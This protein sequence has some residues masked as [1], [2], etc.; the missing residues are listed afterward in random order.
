MHK[1]NYSMAE[2]LGLKLSVY[3]LCTSLSATEL[4]APLKVMVFQCQQDSHIRKYHV[5]FI[6]FSGRA[7]LLFYL[8]EHCCVSCADFAK[9]L[10]F[11]FFLFHLLLN[12]TRRRP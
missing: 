8:C 5:L 12:V 10:D 3:P 6:T 7:N 4:I 1:Q 11:F 2:R 9:A